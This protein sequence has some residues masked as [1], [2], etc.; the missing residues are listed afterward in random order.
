MAD[1]SKNNASPFD[2]AQ[3]WRRALRS[4]AN[5]AAVFA[6]APLA[7]VARLERQFAA[8][9]E[10][11]YEFFAQLMA[12][13]PGYPGVVL[14]RAYYWWTLDQCSLQTFIGYGAYFAHRMSRVGEHVY[15]GPYA[16]VGAAEIGTWAMI[17]TRASLLSGGALHALDDSGR[18]LPS[19]LTR[20]RRI[21]VGS[22]AW[23][24]EG[25]ILMADV[26][27]RANVAVG[28]VVSAPVA[29]GVVVA[30]N[31]ARF[32]RHLHPASAVESR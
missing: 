24:G 17:G 22:H 2:E 8:G 5:G 25:A 20:V 28:A 30:G 9:S 23:I 1:D 13:V 4:L 15:I 6:L 32:V 14:R 3:G 27:C 7:L 19:D 29:D 16:V 10:G 12:G 21:Q 26:G 11:C 18:W 31:P